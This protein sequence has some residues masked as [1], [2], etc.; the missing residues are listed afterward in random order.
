[1]EGIS[2]PRQRKPGWGTHYYSGAPIVRM[3]HRE[4][5]ERHTEFGLQARQLSKIPSQKRQVPHGLKPLGDDKNI[6]GLSGT[7]EAMPFQN[8]IKLGFL[9]S[10]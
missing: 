1:M 3:G 10:L 6:E 7:A 4:E 2:P 8:K 5:K 9:R